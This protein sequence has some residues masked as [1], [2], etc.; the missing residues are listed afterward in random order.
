MCWG[1]WVEVEED[2]RGGNAAPAAAA[3]AQHELKEDPIRFQT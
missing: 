2:E 1:M 3:D